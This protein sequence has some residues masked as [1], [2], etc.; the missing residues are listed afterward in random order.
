MTRRNTGENF[1]KKMRDKNQEE[2]E[3]RSEK[4]LTRANK[5]SKGTQS[6]ERKR[7]EGGSNQKCYKD[8]SESKKKIGIIEIRMTLFGITKKNSI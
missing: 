4:G 5:W 8:N 3:T 7:P 6:G 2:E 1:P